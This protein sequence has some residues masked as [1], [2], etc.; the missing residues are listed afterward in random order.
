[1]KLGLQINNFA[2]SGGP[3]RMGATLAAIART[4]DEAGFAVIGVADHL[5][6]G[7]YLGGPLAPE[8][9]S[10]VALGVVA[11]NTRRAKLTHMVAGVHLRPPAVLAKAVTT[12]DVVS[13]G[14]AWLGI[15]AG[16]YEEEAAGMGVPFPPVAEHFEMLEEALQICLRLWRG[17]HGD[18]RPFVG[19]HYRLE[20][21]LNLPQSLTRPHPPIMIAGQGEQKTLRLV[22]RYGDACS[23]SPGPQ[24]PH[25]LD[26]LRRHCEAEGRDYDAIEKTCAF[27]FDIG[28]DGGK[29]GELIAQLRGLADMG[30]ETVIGDMPHADRITPIEIVGRE[31]IPA[32]AA[33]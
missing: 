26:V 17:E 1:M 8:L 19:K 5:W 10:C 15:G 16:W 6:Q 27:R 25:K 4:A 31:V 28:S 14:R 2:W 21:P 29:T 11:A 23:L 33:F 9:E 24:L 30:I 7:P 13:G 32:V 22:A 12:L 20:R 18:E 3:E